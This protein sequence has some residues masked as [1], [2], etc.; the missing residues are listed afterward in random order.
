MN[1]DHPVLVHGKPH[2]VGNFVD[3]PETHVLKQRQRI[4]QRNRAFRVIDL[5]TNLVCG[6]TGGPVKGHPDT[7]VGHQGFD[8]ADILKR[9]SGAIM[10]PITRIKGAGIAIQKA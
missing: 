2:F 1:H 7:A 3:H 4:R 8:L 6:H 10:S 9:L 5:E